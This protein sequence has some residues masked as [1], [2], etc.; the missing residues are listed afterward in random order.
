MQTLEAFNTD[1]RKQYHFLTWNE[2]VGKRDSVSNVRRGAVRQQP[3][4]YPDFFPPAEGHPL[5]QER[6]R[7]SWVSRRVICSAGNYSAVLRETGL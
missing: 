1:R 2:P 6:L 5:R 3:K 7:L 4:P